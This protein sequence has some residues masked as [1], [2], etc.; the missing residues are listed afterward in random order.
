MA[1]RPAAPAP[2]ASAH[3]SFGHRV[4]I[5][6]AVVLGL[7]LL[8]L[9][10]ARVWPA[11]AS[12]L[13]PSRPAAAGPAA[14]G[15][16][17]PA[18]PPVAAQPRQALTG[19]GATAGAAQ[20]GPMAAQ[21]QGW[22]GA[23]A[24][25]PPGLALHCAGPDLEMLRQTSVPDWLQQQRQQADPLA[26]AVAWVLISQG[27]GLAPIRM[28]CRDD[29]CGPTP[30]DTQRWTQQR[31]AQRA[32]ALPS[33]VR[34]AQG[35]GEP[36]VYALAWRACRS[37]AAPAASGCA[38]LSPERWVA[39]APQAS[40]A[41][42]ALAAQAQARGDAAGSEAALH[43]AIQ[44]PALQLTRHLLLQSAE[45]RLPGDWPADLR[46]T[47]LLDLLSSDEALATE[48]L[49]PV[50]GFCQ[51]EALAAEPAR[52]ALCRQWADRLATQAPDMMSA[53]LGL[54]L[55]ARTGWPEHQV[56]QARDELEALQAHWAKVQALSDALDGSRGLERTC[57]A[58]V[59]LQAHLH[60]V[61]QQG[62]LAVLR[63]A[64]AQRPTPPGPAA[65][66][67]PR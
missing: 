56:A 25:A 14:D 48:E 61:A 33:L 8:A 15:S 64:M 6:L 67:G 65:P 45:S 5:G 57:E 18:R 24:P 49:R 46:L 16:V 42:L 19:S 21:A 1:V 41:W 53:K 37:A 34:L 30:R 3:L 63:Q 10:G 36:A 55:A 38:S 13:W 40:S 4:L 39:M 54:S 12:G 11:L 31:D 58:A 59:R 62:E 47:M 32:Q 52:L 9:L 20:A 60:Q 35:S 51:A 17:H 27:V 29:I 50:L 43:Q 66:A 2:S 7:A 26:K 22:A 28:V 23:S 44:L